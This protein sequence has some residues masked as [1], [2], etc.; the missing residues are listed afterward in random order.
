MISIGLAAWAA[1][2]TYRDAKSRG[3][4]AWVW[5]A[6]ALLFFPLG[7][8]IYLIVRTFSKPKNPA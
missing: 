1:W 3:M 6:V 2:W 5:T 4:T 7:F 8:I